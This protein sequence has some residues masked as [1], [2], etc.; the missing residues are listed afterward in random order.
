M[1][2]LFILIMITPSYRLYSQTIY[3]TVT[4]EKV[5]P[6]SGASVIAY[7]TYNEN[8]LGFGI[9]DK[10]GL[11]KFSLKENQDSIRIVCRSL[12]YTL[13]EKI[14]NVSTKPIHFTLA[15]SNQYLKELEVKAKP[16][17]EE[18]DTLNYNVATFEKEGDESIEDVLKR[19]PGIDVNEDGKI[20]YQGRIINKF[21][22]E[23][24][25]LMGSQYSITSK[26]LPKNAVVSVEVLKD[27]QPIKMLK[28]VVYSIDPAINIVLKQGVTI[29]GNIELGGG[30][31]N[32]W[33][34][35]VTPM[36]FNKKHQTINVLSSTN[37]GQDELSAFNSV[38]LFDYLEFGFIESNPQFLLG[39]TPLESSLF[40]KSEYNNHRTHTATTNYLTGLGKG[41]LKVNIDTYY[42]SRFQ[43][44]SSNS[45]YF[46]RNDTIEIPFSQHST[47][48]TKYLKTRLT[49]EHNSEK[50]YFK[51]DFHFKV[52]NRNENSE[53]IQNEE[54]IPQTADRYFYSIGNKFSKVLKLRNTYYKINLYSEY[55]NTPEQ[56]NFIGGPLMD[57][58]IFRNLN[59]VYQK[60]H[61]NNVK[62]YISTNIIKKW[63]RI[64]FD[65]KFS[66][67]YEWKTLS[68]SIPINSLDENNIY[69][70]KMEYLSIIPM[71][72]PA[73]NY[74]HKNVS[75]TVNPYISLQTRKL[76]NHLL[77]EESFVK[78]LI[79]EPTTYIKYNT[80]GVKLEGSY[81]YSNN[82]TE[83]PQIYSGLIINNYNNANQKNTPILKTKEHSFR[84][85]ISYELTAASLNLYASYEYNITNKDWIQS[86]EVSEDGVTLIQT[87]YLDNNDGVNQKIKSNFDWFLLSTKTMIKGN[88]EIG[89]NVENVILNNEVN[90]NTNSHLS[91]RVMLD[92]P[93]IRNLN[94][95]TYL[96]EYISKSIYKE[97]NQVNWRQRI[98]GIELQFSKKKHLFKWSNKWITHTF[99]DND[100]LYMD[101]SYQYK[102]NKKTRLILTAQNL[103]NHHSYTQTTVN[104]FQSNL[105]YFYLRP[106][107]FMAQIKFKI[108]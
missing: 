19:M 16:I 103:L 2:F 18:G 44:L 92:F 9:S 49:Y 64:T 13:T 46:I 11:F 65:T 37:S 61:Q 79:F 1:K 31:P 94:I 30:I 14:I 40:N 25:D 56:L 75:L 42:D 101:L 24:K 35:K 34:G 71:V 89:Q 6:I 74:K 3:G 51:N 90:K 23:G 12:G 88:I 53:F 78:Q 93:V 68:S 22:V 96:N 69:N 10:D 98:L 5:K 41:D 8:I 21:Y 73:I 55:T 26:N 43:D 85:N 81:K 107:Q 33:Y 97:Q 83:L 60:T 99:V 36:V 47:F 67:N 76:I 58:E 87:K 100:F 48:T 45:I 80:L 70:N 95:S 27:H 104:S 106:R 54:Y 29:T 63:K 108:H 66:L 28:D 82:Y 59:K 7:K 39:N 17:T 72:N 50:N 15:V 4:N 77:N 84:S 38:N 32:I 105:S 57:I 102:F 52:S 62:F 86:Y 91:W 20:S